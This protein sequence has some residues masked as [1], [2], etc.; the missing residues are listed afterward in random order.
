MTAHECYLI[1]LKKFTYISTKKPEM[2]KLGIFEL[3]KIYH[4]DCIEMMKNIPDNSI[5]LIFAAPLYNLQLNSELYRPDQTKVD[6]VNDAWDK[7]QSFEEYNKF[8]ISWLQEC[9]RILKNT[10]SFWVIGTYHNIFRVGTILQNI[11][12]W[13]LNDIIWIKT[14]PMP[15]FKGT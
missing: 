5:D 7:F 1:K 13:I 14:N 15:N 11:G 9:Y 8:T 2:E 4:G 10:G 6:A 3:N 12:Y